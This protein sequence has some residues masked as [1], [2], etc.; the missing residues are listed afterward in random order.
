MMILTSA[1]IMLLNI[2]MVNI[3]KRYILSLLFKENYINEIQG[4]YLKNAQRCQRDKILDSWNG[5]DK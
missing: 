4:K 1:K 3:V 2:A 5:Q